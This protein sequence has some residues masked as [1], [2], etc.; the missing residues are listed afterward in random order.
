[1]HLIENSSMLSSIF[2]IQGNQ[3]R[4]TLSGPSLCLEQ[5]RTATCRKFQ[6]PAVRKVKK[7]KDSL[8]VLIVLDL[9]LL[10]TGTKVKRP[11]IET[12][13]CVD[14]CLSEAIK[15]TVTCSQ[16]RVQLL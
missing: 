15:F 7:K 6:Q 11:N 16:W 3:N 9:R 5:L 13:Q 10:Q 2:W 14:T 12:G 4:C 8:Q 1:M